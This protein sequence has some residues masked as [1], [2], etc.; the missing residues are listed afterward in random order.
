MAKHGLRK[1]ARL[2]RLHRVARHVA[3]RNVAPRRVVV[4]VHAPAAADGARRRQRRRGAGAKALVPRAGGGQRRADDGAAARAGAEAPREPGLEPGGGEEREGDEEDEGPQHHVEAGR[5]REVE[6]QRGVDEGE[7]PERGAEAVLVR[8]QRPLER[9]LRAHE[10]PVVQHAQGPLR[11]EAEHD[12]DAE[13]LV[14]G[15][16]GL[17]LG[18]S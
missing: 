18:G 13:D 12:D 8:H 6:A 3:E 16:E 14:R 1:L 15:F 4:L 2:R 11:E 17:G 9:A 7:R 10:V 5:Q